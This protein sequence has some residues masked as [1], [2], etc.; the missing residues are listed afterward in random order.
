MI[1]TKYQA[2]LI[3]KLVSEHLKNQDLP[4]L[5]QGLMLELEQDLSTFILL[6]REANEKGAGG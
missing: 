2:I 3:A 6:E 1:L 4:S 5:E